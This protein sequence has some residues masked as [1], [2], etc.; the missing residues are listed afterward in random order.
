MGGPGALLLRDRMGG[1][2]HLGRDR[3]D[4]RQ[5]VAAAGACGMKL[6]KAG[7]QQREGMKPLLAALGAREGATRYVGGCVRDTLLGLP[8]SDVD[9]ATRLTPE[10]VMERLA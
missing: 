7:W 9:L 3:G 6:P 5:S 1:A 2:P 8:V 10:A 4:D